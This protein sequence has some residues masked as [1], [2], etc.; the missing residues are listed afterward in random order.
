MKSI[1]AGIPRLRLASILA[2][3]FAA[4]AFAGQRTQSFDSDPN[5]EGANNHLAPAKERQVTQDFGYSATNH[6]G[7]GG[8]MG[9]TVT[10]ASEPAFYADKIPVK[11]LDD[12]LSASGTF[13]L[14]KTS[15]GAGL[16]FGFF[17]AEQPGGSGRPTGSLGLDMDCE[18]SGGRLAVRLITAKN[19]SCGTFVTSY[20][21]GKYRPTPIRKDGTR[22]TW[23]LDYDPAGANGLGQFTFSFHG[24][25]PKPEEFE[26]ANLPETHLAEARKR[27]P[28]TT[29]FTVDLP[30]GFKQQGTTFDHFGLMNAMKPGGQATIYF[31]DLHYL[32]RAQ[33]FAKDPQWDGAGNR[34]TYK[35]TDA[36]GAQNFGFAKTQLAGGAAAGELGGWFWRTEGPVGSYADRVGPLSLDDQL[37]ARGKVAFASGAPDSGMLIGW[38]NSKTVDQKNGLK[39]FV[40][41][42][43]E[44]PTRVGHYFAPVVAG[45]DGVFGKVSSAPV[46]PPDKKSRNFSIEYD[47]K[48]NGG[49]GAVVVHLGDESV[50]LNLKPRDGKTATLD[51]FGVFTPRAGGGLVKISFDDLQYT[52]GR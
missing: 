40:G 11:T 48:A 1:V 18:Q 44:G 51:R 23:K 6:A 34:A 25:L 36:V 46:L 28:I 19:Q 47:P 41:V 3:V 39:D 37:V 20:L 42:R 16:F 27:F 38:F 9:G 22:Y 10:R 43:V 30:A 45:S 5:W 26:N 50:T 14:T 15:G 7:A 2:C 49:N 8:E 13:A 4:G 33:D 35:P 12:R 52:S 32:D 29:T 17:R 24:D 31:D 21:P